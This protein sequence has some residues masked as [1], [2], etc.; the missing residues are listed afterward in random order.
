M[1]LH[2]GPSRGD[3]TTSVSSENV[4]HGRFRGILALRKIPIGRIQ[5]REVDAQNNLP[6]GR[7]RVCD[8]DEPRLF[9][10]DKSL[11]DPCFHADDCRMKGFSKLSFE[12]R[13]VGPQQ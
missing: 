13:I 4:R 1:T 7:H 11:N 12:G 2:A 9:N 8:F 10:S 3:Y 5:R 6:S